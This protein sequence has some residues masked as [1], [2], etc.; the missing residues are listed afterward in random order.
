[1]VVVL[2]LMPWGSVPHAAPSKGPSLQ[3]VS[4]ASAIVDDTGM[5]EVSL[6]TVILVVATARLDSGNDRY[7]S[8]RVG[9]TLQV[10]RRSGSMVSGGEYMVHL[11][12]KD[13]GSLPGLPSFLCTDSALDSV[14]LFRQRD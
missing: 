10:Q 3:I 9:S 12:T 7:Q 5:S 11:L 8:H 2:N 14:D 4:P 13:E 6:H 1:M